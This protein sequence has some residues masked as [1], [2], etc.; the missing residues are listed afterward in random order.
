MGDPTDSNRFVWV[1]LL[2]PET[3]L[4]DTTDS[5]GL[6]WVTLLTPRDKAG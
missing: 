4:G 6:V 1:T 3:C 5:E 2:T